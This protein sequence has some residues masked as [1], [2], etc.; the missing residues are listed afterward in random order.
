MRWLQGYPISK[1]SKPTG[2]RCSMPS[3]PQMRDFR[4]NVPV[5]SK[6]LAGLP[7]GRETPNAETWPAEAAILPDTVAF[8]AS[9]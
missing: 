4:L 8:A 1:N 2:C 7:R 5:G 6:A 9:W 3:V